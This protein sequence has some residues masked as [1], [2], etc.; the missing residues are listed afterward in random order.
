MGKEVQYDATPLFIYYLY[1]P[2][3][4]KFHQVQDL[5]YFVFY[6]LYLQQLPKCLKHGI[7]IRG[8]NKQI[9]HLS[10]HYSR[11]MPLISFLSTPAV[12]LAS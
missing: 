11:Y 10:I 12:P 4:C 7:N 8:S 3:K 5:A 6:L 1:F 9:D 2:L